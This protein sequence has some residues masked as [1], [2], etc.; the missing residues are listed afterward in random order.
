[1]V[2]TCEEDLDQ[3]Q[4][5][6]NCAPTHPSPQPNNSQQITSKGQCWVRGGE[7]RGRDAVAQILTLILNFLL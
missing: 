7:G 5:L 3:R 2:W 6:S 1:M 4:C